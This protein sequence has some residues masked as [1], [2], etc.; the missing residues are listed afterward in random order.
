LAAR[1]GGEEFEQQGLG[2]F[3]LAVSH[4]G[5]AA[6]GFGMKGGSRAGVVSSLR[7]D[8][9]KD[10]NL[11]F[12][13]AILKA[14]RKSLAHCPRSP[15]PAARPTATGLP[16]PPPRRSLGPSPPTPPL[17]R[18]RQASSNGKKAARRGS[19][20]PLGRPVRRRG[21]NKPPSRRRGFIVLLK[22]LAMRQKLA[23][24]PHRPSV[25]HW[26]EHRQSA[27][28]GSTDWHNG[29]RGT[30]SISSGQRTKDGNKTFDDGPAHPDRD[31]G[32]IRP[33]RG[34][35]VPPLRRQGGA[36]FVLRRQGRAAARSIASPQPPRARDW[37]SSPSCKPTGDRRGG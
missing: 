8:D 31:E 24:V 37:S 35:V 5:S 4:A 18:L 27:C 13:G 14:Q 2:G 20:T 21:K 25:A 32:A 33:P 15:H 11:N 1:D 6:T 16:R 26:N 30:P 36:F 17:A 34:T 7:E 9:R 22:Q 23:V 28:S 10:V 3:Q 29:P 12:A 19:S